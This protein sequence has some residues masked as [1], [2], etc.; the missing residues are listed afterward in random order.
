MQQALEEQETSLRREKEEALKT[1]QRLMDA[2]REIEERDSLLKFFNSNPPSSGGGN[3]NPNQNAILAE[4]ERDK[5]R[6]EIDRLTALVSETRQ[7]DREGFFAL[8]DKD[9]VSWLMTDDV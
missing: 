7:S 1:Q 8:N 9:L 5:L 6:M 4:R 3:V 2:Q